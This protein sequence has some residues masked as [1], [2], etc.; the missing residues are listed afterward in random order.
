MQTVKVRYN[1]TWRRGKHKSM[2]ES[3]F[4]PWKKSNKVK[5]VQETNAMRFGKDQPVSNS[6]HCSG[7]IFIDSTEFPRR[8]VFLVAL[9]E[10]GSS[11]EMV[12]RPWSHLFILEFPSC[13]LKILLSTNSS[14]L[15]V[16][17]LPS[18]KQLLPVKAR[19]KG[20]RNMM[21]G[22]WS[23]LPDWRL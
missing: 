14:W 9:L 22:G 10:D 12:L 18:G 5:S 7:D 1:H 15:S 17:L 21:W 23:S 6:S 2:K 19:G 20:L 4:S 16:P 11:G 8:T 3:M 13:Y